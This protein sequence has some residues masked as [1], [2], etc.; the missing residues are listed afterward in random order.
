MP[1]ILVGAGSRHHSDVHL[2]RWPRSCFGCPPRGVCPTA[3][4]PRQ[5][6]LTTP[7]QRVHRKGIAFDLQIPPEIALAPF[8][9]L[10]CKG[11]ATSPKSRSAQSLSRATLPPATAIREA[12]K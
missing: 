2:C 1:T 9:A 12:S 11:I 3:G 7:P 5:R 6:P 4:G 8:C 10:I